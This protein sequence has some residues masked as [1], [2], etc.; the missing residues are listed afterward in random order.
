MSNLPF[1]SLYPVFPWTGIMLCGYLFGMFYLKNVERRNFGNIVNFSFYSGA[2]CLSMFLI[3]RVINGIGNRLYWNRFNLLEFFALSKYPP[4]LTFL[5]FT[6]GICFLLISASIFLAQ[7]KGVVGKVYDFICVF[8]RVPL[9]FYTIHL[10]VYGVL[11]LFAGLRKPVPLLYVYI[12][13]SAG[14][15]LLYYPCKWFFAFKESSKNLT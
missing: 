15:V 4:S 2:F 1:F 7:K 10:Y 6:S 11:P 12:I 14:I 3:L 8:G 13:W 5:F 9:F